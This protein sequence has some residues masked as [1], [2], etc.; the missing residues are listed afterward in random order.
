M[1]QPRAGEGSVQIALRLPLELR[2]K[3]RKAAEERG[4]SMNSELV[5]RVEESFHRQEGLVTLSHRELEF[6]IHQSVKALGG[7]DFEAKRHLWDKDAGQTGDA[8]ESTRTP[9]DKV[10]I[11]TR[12]V[13]NVAWIG[14]TE[15]FDKDD[16]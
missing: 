5:A 4:R 3:V 10:S 12:S 15:P 2:D 1:V 8:G 9:E 11:R 14:T 16:D 13:G 6:I 7:P